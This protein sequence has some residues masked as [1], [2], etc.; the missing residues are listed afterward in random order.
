M[1]RSGPKT[2]VYWQL[3]RKE[4]TLYELVAKKR[5]IRRRGQ[6]EQMRGEQ[7]AS[8]TFSAKLWRLRNR[9]WGRQPGKLGG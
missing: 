6:N 4:L 9:G 7:T 1:E 3:R 2:G 5:S 8:R